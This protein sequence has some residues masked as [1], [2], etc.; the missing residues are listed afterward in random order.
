MQPPKRPHRR[1]RKATEMAG[2]VEGKRA[3]VTGAGMGIGRATALKP[4]GEG[5]VCGRID[6][7]E[8]AA[9]DTSAAIEGAGG[10]AIVL[11]AD[12]TDEDQVA[13]A[14]AIAVERWGGLD[15]VVP[16]AGVLWAGKDDRAD[17]LDAVVWRRV[18]DINL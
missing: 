9:K 6:L 2:R 8:G 18:I 13:G 16:N 12:V 4:A 3:V 15:I 11:A 1:R 17:R 10:E 14:V 5:A 7:N